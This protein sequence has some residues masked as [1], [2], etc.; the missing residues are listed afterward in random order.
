[1]KVLSLFDGISVG[2]VALERAG[3]PVERY[4]ASEIDK[5]AIKI[6]KKNYPQIV[7]IGDVTTFKPNPLSEVDLLIGGF[8]CQSFSRSGHRRGF[9]DPRGQLFYQ[10]VRILD[11]LKPKWFLAENVVMDVDN[12]NRI[13]NELFDTMYPESD[14]EIIDSE[15]I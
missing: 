6:S 5:A 8:S 3:I 7:H 2:M 11:R 15:S 12:C 10:Y 1:M 14:W 9:D 4:V 13:D